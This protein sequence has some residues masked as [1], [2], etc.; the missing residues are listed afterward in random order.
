MTTLFN[1]F[2]KEDLARIELVNLR[3]SCEKACANGTCPLRNCE[4][5]TCWRQRAVNKIVVKTNLNPVRYGFE[6]QVTVKGGELHV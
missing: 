5:C 3:R 4:Y 6:L 1:Y 2:S